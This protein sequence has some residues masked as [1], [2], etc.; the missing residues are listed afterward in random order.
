MATISP[1]KRKDGSLVYTAQIR[2]KINGLS[3]TETKS[4]KDRRF[5]KLWA[6]K[7]ESELREP[8]ALERER[9]AGTTVGMVLDWYKQDFQGGTK[10]GRTKL[11]HIE[12]LERCESFA[13]LDA[14]KLSASDLIAHAHSR[15]RDGAAPSTIHNDFIWLRNAMQAVRL[16]RNIPLNLQAVEDAV[17]L[18]KRE[19]VIGASRRRNRRPTL[20]ELNAVLAYFSERDGRASLPMVDITLFALFSTRRQDEICRI[21]WADIDEKRQGVLVRDMKHPR[22][23]VDTFVHLP[24]EAWQVM[25][26]Q[27]RESERIFPYLGKSVSAAFTRGCKMAGVD[28]LRFHDLRHEGVSRLFELGWDIPRVAG[29][30][31]HKSWSSL[32]RYTHLRDVGVTD[33]YAGWQY[34]P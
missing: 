18:L 34:L 29:V 32:Q 30:S 28:D 10:F 27:P 21:T 22:Y 33:K 20:D 19:R 24:D 12:Y 25:Q 2:I 3:H 5:L 23:K 9:H 7:R 11:G 8:G 1:R 14:V 17:A 4:H 15:A 26:R 31:G 16:S 13:V 6:Q